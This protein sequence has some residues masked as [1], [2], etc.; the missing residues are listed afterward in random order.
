MN[1]KNYVLII[2][3]IGIIFLAGGAGAT[4]N[5]TMAT[6]A[7]E[8]CGMEIEKEDAS[9]FLIVSS[10]GAEHWGCCPIC[11]MVEAIYYNNSELQGQC[12]SC[13]K[14]IGL[15]FTDGE[16]SWASFSGNSEF[17]RV[18]LG[19]SCMTN[20][21]TCSTACSTAISLSYDWASN[22]PQKTLQESANIAETK[23]SSFTIAYR[24]T[25]IPL[26]NYALIG[27]GI[28]LISVALIALIIQKRK[29]S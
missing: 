11:G 21:L 7:C 25:K 28:S 14:P 13:G 16:L 23:L 24:P 2:A 19:G 9:S 6:V 27:I 15:N 3:L 18:I 20:K 29:N 26:L 17:I 1:I 10:D 22:V 4:I 5:R 8:A 12:F